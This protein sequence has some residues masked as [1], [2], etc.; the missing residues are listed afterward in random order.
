MSNPFYRPVTPAQIPVV[1]G[2]TFPQFMSAM[3]GKNP[4]QIL[5]ELVSTGRVSQQQLDVAQQRARQ[6][7]GA[8]DGFRKMFGF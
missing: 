5:N 4:A 2:V 3:R 6:M 1:S 8:F 7:G